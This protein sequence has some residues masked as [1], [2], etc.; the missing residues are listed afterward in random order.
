MGPPSLSCSSPPN[1]LFR[2]HPSG[3][4]PR[5]HPPPSRG[6][7]CPVSVRAGW[8]GLW[9]QIASRM[10]TGVPPRG[11][12]GSTPQPSGRGQPQTG[13]TPA[14]S[15]SRSSEAL[16]SSLAGSPG[17]FFQGSVP[18]PRAQPPAPGAAWRGWT[19]GVRPAECSRS[20]GGP[21][22]PWWG[23]TWPAS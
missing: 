5:P 8:L 21:W 22:L 23:A 19:P 2:A 16:P 7:S 15:T 11:E 20:V 12:A 18:L 6:A 13:V 9:W 14:S 4:R 3:S 10:A 17:T 1:L